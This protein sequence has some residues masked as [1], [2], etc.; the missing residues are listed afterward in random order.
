MGTI[1]PT[2][3]CATDYNHDKEDENDDNDDECADDGDEDDDEDV[4]EVN[5]YAT[6]IA[7]C[8][9]HDDDISDDW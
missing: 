5:D 3:R 7:V 9:D 1:I 6:D 2:W 8:H 4:D